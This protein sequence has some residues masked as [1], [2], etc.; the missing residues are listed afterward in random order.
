MLPRDAE[1]AW[2]DHTSSPAAVAALLAPREGTV[3]VAV[4]P[5]VSD[6]AND[7]PEVIVP[8]EPLPAD[9]PGA[10]QTLF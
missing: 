9:P 1:A 5:G 2:L 7:T 6:P 10:E 3:R 4:G 8:V